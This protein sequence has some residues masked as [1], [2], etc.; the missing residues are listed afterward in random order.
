MWF[1]LLTVLF[2]T[3]SFAQSGLP[4]RTRIEGFFGG[5]WMC[6]SVSM[7]DL[8]RVDCQATP[9]Y[10]V[11]YE[12]V[13]DIESVFQEVLFQQ[14]AKTG[15]E[16]TQCLNTF[17]N[18]YAPP[19]RESFLTPGT[20]L[21]VHTPSSYQAQQEYQAGALA[22]SQSVSRPFNQ[23]AWDKFKEIRDNLRG[24]I[25][26]KADKQ[27]QLTA[28]RM[29][30]DPGDHSRAESLRRQ[31]QATLQSEV[32][33]ISDAIKIM[34]AQVPLG[35]MLD[36]YSVIMDMASEDNL[37]SQATFENTY[38]DSLLR[39]RDGIRRSVKSY[40]SALRSDGTYNLD[41]Q[42]RLALAQ[43]GGVK[44]LIQS[45]VRDQDLRDKLSCRMR[46]YYVSGPQ[47][48]RIVEL[49]ALTAAS[50]GTYSIASAPLRL[51]ANLSVTGATAVQINYAVQ[52]RCSQPP[53]VAGTG[54]C[55]AE[56]MAAAATHE[57]SMAMCA[58]SIIF[59]V[60]SGGMEIAR[61]FPH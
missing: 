28:V 21:R 10:A 13:R 19:V 51:M 43:G 32:A 26:L 3:P 1:L 40:D 23:M 2:S 53:V 17:L 54:S 8:R 24:L 31:R 55:D 50:F 16:Q 38:R 61:F 14:A 29:G 36:V 45:G 4:T 7:D 44:E 5:S 27:S 35:T 18:L 46:A 48:T 25:Q 41:R 39:V 15:H 33:A 52:D 22:A 57:A 56:G 30:A 11:I 47:T 58:A 9:N 60:A 42:H 59:S 6:D 37:P 49:L 20:R 34:V 12:N